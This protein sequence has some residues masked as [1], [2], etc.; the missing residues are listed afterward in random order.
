M[1][2]AIPGLGEIHSPSRR[3]YR[4]PSARNAVHLH[5]GIVFT[6]RQESRSP[7]TGMRSSTVVADQFRKNDFKLCLTVSMLIFT[8]TFSPST[9]RRQDEATVRDANRAALTGITSRDSFPGHCSSPGTLVLL[10]LLGGR[11]HR[12]E[13]SFEGES[14]AIFRP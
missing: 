6:F 3:N 2:N 7:C 12:V 13:P 11:K 5:P 8:L 10:L 4:S 1:V 9:N 14:I